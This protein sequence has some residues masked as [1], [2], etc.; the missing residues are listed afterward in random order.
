MYRDQGGFSFAGGDPISDFQ[1]GIDATKLYVSAAAGETGSK[2]AL[3]KFK[4][5]EKK[6]A[7]KLSSIVASAQ[8]IGTRRGKRGTKPGS[9]AKKR[10]ASAGERFSKGK[11]VTRD[12]K[13]VL[14]ENNVESSEPSSSS[15]DGKSRAEPDDINMADLPDGESIYKG[16]RDSA[17]EGASAS[18]FYDPRDNQAPMVIPTL[19]PAPGRQRLIWKYVREIMEHNRDDPAKL[20]SCINLMQIGAQLDT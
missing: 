6:E 15:F 12:A 7:A 19:L 8:E 11:D 4:K 20:M 2:K 14:K 9:K 16:W 13:L 3:K 1:K 17:G 5:A 10:S 18:G